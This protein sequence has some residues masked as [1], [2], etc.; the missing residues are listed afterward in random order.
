MPDRVVLLVGTRKGAFIVE[1]DAERTQWSVRSSS[2]MGQNVM[3]MNYDPR[4]GTTLAAVGDPWFGSRVY[5]SNDLGQTWDE[6]QVG[7]TFPADS[8]RSLEKIWHV[9]PGRADEPG[10]LYAGV[11]PAALFKSTDD[12]Q[13]WDFVPSLEAHPTRAEWQPGAGGLCLHTIVL[14]PL[15]SLHMYVGISAAGVFETRDG[16]GSWN[17]ANEGTRVNFMPDQPST[18]AE[19]GQCVHKVV[20]SPSLPGRL[21][22]QNHC[23]VYRSDDAGAHWQEISEG[24]PSDFGFG[25]AVHPHDPETIW[26]CPA[27]SGYEHWMPGARVVVYRSRDGGRTWQA[28]D[29][30][31][32]GEGSYLNVLREGMAADAMPTAGIYIGTNTGQLFASADEGEHWQQVPSLLPPINSV[33]AVTL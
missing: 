6:P 12:G 29:Q 23:G 8:G 11:E 14:D 31:L 2:H 22:Q 3:H 5:R 10:V 30:G 4:T 20:A 13:T 24:L 21:Y 17:P 9:S 25:I 28:L 26:V 16:G 19:W 27:I 1:G 33:T 7:I 18:Y 32:P 15:D